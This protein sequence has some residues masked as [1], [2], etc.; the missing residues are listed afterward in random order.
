MVLRQHRV[1]HVKN[2]EQM[3]QLLSSPQDVSAKYIVSVQYSS[4]NTENALGENK[5][6]QLNLLPVLC[7]L[8]TE[9]GDSSER[10][11][12]PRKIRIKTHALDACYSCISHTLHYLSNC[13]KSSNVDSELRVQNQVRTK[14][15]LN[16]AV[17]E[18]A[19]DLL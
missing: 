5:A 8:N 13:Q 7:T 16:I 12:H 19:L 15:S 3:L 10:I 2:Q 17:K 18:A 1:D 4:M 11:V 14:D 9:N 6:C